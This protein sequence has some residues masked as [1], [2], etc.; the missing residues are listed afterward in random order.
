MARVEFDIV[1]NSGR[2]RDVRLSMGDL[3]NDVDSRIDGRLDAL[4]QSSAGVS[5]MTTHGR[6][7]DRWNYHFSRGRD[8][9]IVRI[10]GS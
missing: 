6:G 3:Q 10:S 4:S 9:T 8:L 2:L 5:Q 1:G 7:G